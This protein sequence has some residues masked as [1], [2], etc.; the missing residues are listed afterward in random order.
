MDSLEG[1]GTPDSPS[2]SIPLLDR[3]S[4]LREKAEEL[5]LH[6]SFEAAKSFCMAARWSW[7]QIWA[8]RGKALA[9]DGRLLLEYGRSMATGR[10]LL[11]LVDVKQLSADE[12]EKLACYMESCRARFRFGRIL[13]QEGEDKAA[14]AM[15]EF[16]KSSPKVRSEPDSPT[17]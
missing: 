13:L 16:H 4:Q 15:M 14:S 7:W 3:L 8:E 2:E 17:S 11:Q 1:D 12:A 9:D 10:D 5:K 6:H